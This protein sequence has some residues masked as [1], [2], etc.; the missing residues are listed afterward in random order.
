MM[1][2]VSAAEVKISDLDWMDIIDFE[3]RESMND[4]ATY[5]LELSEF[6]TK[7]EQIIG[8]DASIKFHDN[9]I[10]S[11]GSADLR[12]FSGVVTQAQ[13]TIDDSANRKV[14]IKVISKIGLLEYSMASAIYQ[15]SSSID[16]LEKVLSRNGI[17]LKIEKSGGPSPK[18]DICVQYN[19]N[20]FNFCKRILAED[21]LMF[22]SHDGKDSDKLILHNSDKPYPKNKMGDVRLK[23][24]QT[25]GEKLYSMEAVS[26]KRSVVAGQYE[27]STYDQGS[28]N[29]KSA[30][31]RTKS[32]SVLLNRSTVSEF[33]AAPNSPSLTQASKLLSASFVFPETML[34]GRTDHPGLFLGQLLEIS[35]SIDQQIVGSY[36]I[37]QLKYTSANTTKPFICQF[38]AAPRN[39]RL[40]PKQLPKP[41]IHGVHNAVV[42]GSTKGDPNCDKEGR[43]KV[44]FFWE[45]ADKSSGWVRVAEQYAGAG[46]GSQFTPRVGQE[47]LV[48]FLHGDPDA[49][50]ITGQVYSAK[51]KPPF[52]EANTTQTGITSK[53]K[54]AANE[55]IF[56]DKKDEE[57]LTLNAARDLNLKALKNSTFQT[58]QAA[59]FKANTHKIKTVPYEGDENDAEESIVLKA[60]ESII[61]MAVSEILME[62]KELIT[63]KVGETSIQISPT[64]IKINAKEVSV[65]AESKFTL[66]GPNGNIE[67]ETELSLKSA[68]IIAEADAELKFEASKIAVKANTSAKLEGL[69]V[70][71]KADTKLDLKGGAMVS[72]DGGG[73]TIIKGGLVKIN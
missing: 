16:I 42:A 4:C 57:L 5:I 72:L 6:S 31:E 60:G 11:S 21:G 52:S 33:R 35:S 22:Y 30:A 9:N 10:R 7:F 61:E 56:D 14:Q 23:D 53:L 39:L 46:Y 51:N 24:R 13:Y 32:K 29:Q 18:R 70:E 55:L 27:V 54:D 15:K 48:S 73:S 43:V 19:E 41:L 63:L 62:A 26:I 25:L 44:N 49:P 59:I 17:T 34:E 68:N 3:L 65:A 36:M 71:L 50:I 67:A 47:V 64:E 28:A 37:T 45:G 58:Q 8:K 40:V 38:S 1:N 66:T 20:D 2:L 12:D 69:K